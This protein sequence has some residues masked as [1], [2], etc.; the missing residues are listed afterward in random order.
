MDF[1]TFY[2]YY[3]ISEFVTAGWTIEQE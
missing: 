3:I 2:I 1:H